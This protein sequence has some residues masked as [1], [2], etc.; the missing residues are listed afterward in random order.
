MLT[1]IDFDYHAVFPT[2]EIYNV[3]SD[4]PLPYKFHSVERARAEPVPKALFRER[5]IPAQPARD[6]CFSLVRALPPPLSPWGQR[7]GVRGAFPKLTLGRHRLY[8]FSTSGRPSRPWGRK[9]SVMA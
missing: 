7:V 6:A 3:R 5:G 1:A 4:R 9:I 8:T 2:D